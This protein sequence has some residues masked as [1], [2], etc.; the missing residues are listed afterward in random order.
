[1]SLSQSDVTDLAHTYSEQAS[2]RSQHIEDIVTEHVNKEETD[3]EYSETVLATIAD[4]NPQAL[5]QITNFS[6]VDL[7]GIYKVVERAME[8]GSS[9]GRKPKYSGIDAFLLLIVCFK[10][11]DEWW[12]FAKNWKF[13]SPSAAEKFIWK[14][15]DIVYEPLVHHYVRCFSRAEQIDAGWIKVN[16]PFP[17]AIQ[18]TDTK[19]Q[20]TNR[21][22]GRFSE[23]KV[24]FSKKHGA[25][26]IKVEMSHA[27]NR[28]VMYFAKHEPGSIHDYSIFSERLEIHQRYLSKPA[29]DRTL[30]DTGELV[31]E[32]RLF[33]AMLAD[34]GYKGADNRT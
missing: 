22:K 34:K 14:I 11:Y 28:R 9:R 32:F 33:W 26:G 19:F 13:K 20:M 2:Q 21:P 17:E 29:V 24:Y 27:C 12:K 18:V 7:R 25:Y 15:I 4:G 10:F 6:E 5:R 23:K 30:S 16:T 8:N 1:M 3:D 31:K